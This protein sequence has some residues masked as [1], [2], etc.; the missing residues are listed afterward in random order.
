[1]NITEFKVF[2]LCNEINLN[3]VA[4]H[5]GI[6][7]KYDW[8][9]FLTLKEDHLK[10]L[11]KEPE[12][13]MLNLFPYGS[14]VFMNMQ[15][16]E[17]TDI[18]NYLKKIDKNLLNADFNYTDEY[19]LEF[20]DEE[21]GI[22]NDRML[23]NEYFEYQN[24]ILS[25]VLAKSVALERIENDI[26]TLLDEIEVIVE[27]LKRGNLSFSDEKIAKTSAQIL[28]FKYKS[29]S[30]IML[31]DKPDI[32]W[33]N[34]DSEELYVQLSHIFELS[35]RYDKVQAKSETLMDILQAFSNLTHQKRGTK[36]EWM[37]IILI[38]IE[39]L[40]SLVEFLILK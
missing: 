30:Y 14:I 12:S 7:K 39:I 1:M 34:Q 31:L 15:H 3:K 9:D 24:S 6:N 16:H 33:N 26:G 37:V 36:L 35:E 2:S 25:I 40:I 18:V 27:N 21:Q 4:N 8:E 22:N 17:I 32:T 23:V 13:K 11:I 19:C 29:L 28:E 5:F 38:F 10:G 20:S